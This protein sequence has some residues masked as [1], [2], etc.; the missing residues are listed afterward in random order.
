MAAAVPGLIGRWVVLPG[1][2]RLPGPVL[3][4]AV[5]LDLEEPGVKVVQVVLHSP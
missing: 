3:P 4:S 5:E 1:P 2:K